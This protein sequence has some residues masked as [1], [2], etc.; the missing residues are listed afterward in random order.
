MS[1]VVSHSGNQGPSKIDANFD[2]V[3]EHFHGCCHLKYW[4]EKKPLP[5]ERKKREKQIEQATERV[6]QGLQFETPETKEAFVEKLRDDCRTQAFDV[7]TLENELRNLRNAKYR[8]SLARSMHDLAPKLYSLPLDPSLGIKVSVK[9]SREEDRHPAG[10]FSMGITEV[11]CACLCFL[12]WY[13]RESE[14]QKKVY[15]P[16]GPILWEMVANFA[17][18]L[19]NLFLVQGFKQGRWE[20]ISELLVATFGLDEPKRGKRNGRGDFGGEWARKLVANH[21]KK[22]RKRKGFPW[23]PQFPALAELLHKH[24]K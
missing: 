11:T 19:N 12:S 24:N 20:P 23:H 2:L 8:R 18:V 16:P 4:G 3:Y 14:K 10:T 17:S 15:I 9:F 13:I 7:A 21:K 5:S 6:V 1:H 22:F